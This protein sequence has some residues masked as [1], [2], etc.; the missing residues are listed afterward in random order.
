MRA[1]AMIG[2]MR[3]LLGLLLMVWSGQAAAQP[4]IEVR[5]G[6]HP[7][8]S[9]VV[10]DFTQ[11]PE[12]SISV[13]DDR[14][15]IAFDR[16]LA[17]DFGSLPGDPLDRLARPVATTADGGSRVE[18]T[19]MG[20]IRPRHFF[21]GPRLVVD[22][23]DSV[24][25][26]SADAA[27]SR[28]P[29][30]PAIEK[31]S[32]G[33]ASGTDISST[34]AETESEPETVRVTARQ[35]DDGLQLDYPWPEE[36]SA[37]IFK[38]GG[39]LWVVFDEPRPLD[40]S[41]LDWRPDTPLGRRLDSMERPKAEEHTV[42]RYRLAGEQ[43]IA[44][45]REGGVWQVEL[46]D[47][48][49]FPRDA[50]E[51]QRRASAGGK[52]ALFMSAEEVG[53]KLRI[54]DPSAG[55]MIEIVPLGDAGRAMASDRQFAE[56]RLP[57]TAQGVVLVPR[58]EDIELRRYANG[59]GVESENGLALS[60]EFLAAGAAERPRSVLDFAAWRGGGSEN[61]V[62]TE[63]ALLVRLSLAPLA[64]RRA[65]RWELA[66]FYL[67]NGYAAAARGVL[68]LMAETDPTL[69]QTPQWQ[70]VS[71]VVL[72]ELGRPE[73]ALK[74]LLAKELDPETDLWLWR[75]L[76]AEAAGRH[77]DALA[78]YDR[79]KGVISRQDKRF[80]QRLRLAVA[81]AALARGTLDV[82]QNQI[83]SLQEMQLAKPL[84][85]E[86][87]LLY[88]QLAAAR[89]DMATAA[90]RFE[91]ASTARDR[92]VSTAAR[93]ALTRLLLAEGKIERNEA[94]ARLERLRFAWRGD[95]LELELL[96]FLG[97][98]H[99][100]AEQYR[101]GLETLQTAVIAFPDSSEANAVAG[102]MSEAFRRLFL[103]GAADTLSPV[104]ALALFYDFRELTPL[105]AEGDRMIRHL[106]DR[107]V[108]VELLDRAA[109]LLRHQ[110]DFRLEG[111]P[112][113]LVATRLAK[114]YLLDDRPQMALEVME[115]TRD[116]SAPA[117]ILRERS[118]VEARALAE[119]ERAEEALAL[120]EDDDSPAAEQLE[121]DIYWRQRDWPALAALAAEIMSDRWQ[122]RDSLGSAERMFLMRRALAL[123]FLDRSAALR[124][125]RDRYS[126]LM[127]GGEFEAMFN[128]LT[129]EDPPPRGELARIAGN[130]SNVAQYR[131]FLSAYREEFSATAGAAA[132]AL[133]NQ[134]ASAS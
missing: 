7:N 45:S 44:T 102:R 115:T 21:S 11:P 79:G 71:G 54:R 75:A 24:E 48:P 113:A 90:A 124:R 5:S 121:A 47:S 62:E 40:H 9:R 123:S 14:L 3:R 56:F 43:R 87:D 72:L 25:T 20:T 63:Q 127:T 58:S 57:A 42:L 31:P 13:A 95:E 82:A 83:E 30:E 38:R 125:L 116:R 126:P 89:G 85:A 46:R 15:E 39:Y 96:D 16:P 131:A 65:A 32:A 110:V 52:P 37:A 117:E 93:L 133:G 119:L 12:Y 76:A 6:D 41:A 84:A 77:E 49:T 68:D 33:T 111:L 23:V 74:A 8:F 109:D 86:A 105:G 80:R 1:D 130:L 61:F 129:S 66:R 10:F 69:E 17:F 34:T 120:L 27:P 99:L 106:V 73:E 59:I 2:A 94:I 36:T 97:G 70:A 134:P 132:S 29:V 103:E 114:I 107:L 53:P 28:T 26:A 128:L 18:L 67:A 4:T 122:S 19:V 92:R 78:Y 22:V 98:L 100:E 81:R 50:I 64:E 51:P 118:L 91:D 55:D 60:T 101:D 35:L 108:A 104:D 112:R 88:G